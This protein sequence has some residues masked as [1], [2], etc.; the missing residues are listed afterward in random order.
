MKQGEGSFVVILQRRVE[1]TCVALGIS[2]DVARLVA[3]EVVV[4]TQREDGGCEVYIAKP[5]CV[6]DVA[7][8]RALEEVK[9]TG[10]V[11]EA[12]DKNGISRATLYRL[13]GR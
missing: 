5:P 9:R 7:K 8:Q 6:S 13:I 4:R 1:T 12:A 10:R 2:Q 11:A 3:A